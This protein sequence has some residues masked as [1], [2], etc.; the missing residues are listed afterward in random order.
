MQLASSVEQRGAAGA[1]TAIAGTAGT[2]G[3]AAGAAA[4]LLAAAGAAVGSCPDAA[5]AHVLRCIRMA[6][7]YVVSDPGAALR[8]AG[9][10]DEVEVRLDGVEGHALP[11]VVGE[12]QQRSSGGVLAA[13]GSAGAEEEGGAL[14]RLVGWLGEGVWS[15]MK[16]SQRKRV[17]LAAAMVR[18]AFTPSIYRSCT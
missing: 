4:A 11:R 14:C 17:G 10:V 7:P 12:A 16:R 6:L 1:S 15:R 13:R 8:A 3:A 9:Q 5:L 2:A 18:W